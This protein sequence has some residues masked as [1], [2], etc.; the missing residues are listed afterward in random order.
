VFWRTA[1]S[2]GLRAADCARL[3]TL[4]APLTPHHHTRPPPSPS[5]FFAPPTRA[6]SHLFLEVYGRQ[7]RLLDPT[8]DLGDDDVR[9]AIKN[10]SG[11]GGEARRPAALALA[12]PRGE[13]G[14]AGGRGGA[15]STPPHSTPPQ[16]H[17]NPCPTRL[18]ND[19]RLSARSG[20][21]FA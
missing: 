11:T 17:H 9:T 5:P 16:P 20:G 15:G 10:S 3:S 14:C 13:A 6:A 1:A 7:L 18:K 21:R 19:R 4:T 8:R 12:L 2:C